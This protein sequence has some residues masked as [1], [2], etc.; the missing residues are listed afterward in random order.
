FKVFQRDVDKAFRQSLRAE[1]AQRQC[2]V[3]IRGEQSRL[4]LTDVA[5]GTTQ[6]N[7]GRIRA[8]VGRMIEHADQPL[9]L[10]RL[11][12]NTIGSK[13]PL[14][15]CASDSSTVYFGDQLYLDR[16]SRL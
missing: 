5:I 14:E 8:R 16:L 13:T 10:H 12:N 15:V 2:C 3:A 1:V 7:H 4:I 11:T 6:D 9:L